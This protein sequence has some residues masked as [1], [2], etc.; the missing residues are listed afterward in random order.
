MNRLAVLSLILATALP[1]SAKPSFAAPPRVEGH[2]CNFPN[3][4]HGTWV[5]FF[6]G[7]RTV[8]R[9]DGED[10]REHIT[11]WRCFNTKAE[12]TA[13]KYWAQTDYRAGPQLTWCRKK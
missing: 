13:W 2:Y 12:C 3:V 8:T 10:G 4:R 1:I 6:D 9:F 7:S 5:G 11:L